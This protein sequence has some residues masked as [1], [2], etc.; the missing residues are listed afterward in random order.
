MQV[1]GKTKMAV[2]CDPRDLLNFIKRDF[3]P[4]NAMCD[5]GQKCSSAGFTTGARRCGPNWR[6]RSA[7]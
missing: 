4:M 6:K 1:D 5:R 3:M 2:T 7:P